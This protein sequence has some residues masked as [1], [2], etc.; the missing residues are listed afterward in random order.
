MHSESKMIARIVVVLLA[1]LITMPYPSI[2]S[3]VSLGNTPRPLNQ[4]GES[5]DNLFEKSVV[6]VSA[7]ENVTFVVSDNSIDLGNSSAV[8]P[9]ELTVDVV[10]GFT[11]VNKLNSGYAYSLYR[12]V[13]SRDNSF[14]EDEDGLH[15]F[16]SSKDNSK[17][18]ISVYNMT[19]AHSIDVSQNDYVSVAISTNSSYDSSDGYIGIA[20]QLRDQQGVRQYVSIHTS[21]L[22]LADGYTTS[23]Y[24]LGSSLGKNFPY[25][26]FRYGSSS[27]PWFVQLQLARAFATLGLSSASLDGLLVGAELFSI[28][29]PY[30]TTQADV[31]FR[32]ALVHPQPFSINEKTV[33]STQLSFAPTRFLNI[34]G[35]QSSRLK[36]AISGSL[37]PA[38]QKEEYQENGIVKVVDVSYEF[39][40]PLFY[41]FSESS[42]SEVRFEGK[43][44]VTVPSKSVRKC[45]IT[46]NNQTPWD[47]TN[48]VLGRVE[49]GIYLFPS[50]TRSLKVHLVLYK[51]NA[52]LFQ[53]TSAAIPIVT[54]NG[55]TEERFSAETNEVVV[56]VDLDQAGLQEPRIAVRTAGAM[57]GTM[58]V[59]DVQSP[60]DS[61]LLL[62]NDVFLATKI[63][64]GEDASLYTVRC[65]FSSDPV[66]S[67]LTAQPFGVS[68]D[69]DYF[70]IY[71]PLNCEAEVGISVP[72]TIRVFAF[73]T[74]LLRIDYD[75]SALNA[76]SNELMVRKYS[77]Y[78]Y[79]MLK[80]VREG[81]TEIKAYFINPNNQNS[82]VSIPFL[83]N[84][85]RQA[86]YEI[87]P[88]MFLVVSLV[89]LV[90]VVVS[91]DQ[92]SRLLSRLRRKRD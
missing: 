62:S 55:I 89:S 74:F 80:P 66:Y 19:F 64:A 51:F 92:M 17:V 56:L 47:L 40:D 65:S 67:S 73:K 22:Y 81:S 43:V 84:V 15:L 86:I 23:Q 78:V 59:N 10:N 9:S 83:V 6:S 77:S 88:Y 54:K 87:A 68:I 4:G 30:N 29:L 46:V 18:A 50:D 52:W 25:Y 91:R 12:S 26:S 39:P 33:N 11:P 41:N 45:T 14:A 32:Y 27:G 16:Y 2:A 44:N 53:R 48:D 42:V 3:E 21:G 79:F 35:I 38:D 72:M 5:V 34:S 1:V 70:E 37:R 36:A 82:T 8:V 76:D 63:M 71:T 75:V 24:F 28:P 57:S 60:L 31:R 20:L 58:M 49:G 61:L 69:Y 85:K 13:N 7:Y 90:Y